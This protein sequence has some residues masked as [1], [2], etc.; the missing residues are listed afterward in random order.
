MS[1]KIFFTL[2]ILISACYFSQRIIEN[3]NLHVFI[4]EK[5]SVVEFDPN[6]QLV[7]GISK[8]IDLKTG[9]TLIITHKSY[10]MDNAFHCKYFII[11]NLM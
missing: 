6:T 5:I 1:N 3:N 4:G 9:D 10:V 2:F 8:E 7:K 11:K